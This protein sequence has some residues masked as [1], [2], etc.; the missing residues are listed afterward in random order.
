VAERGEGGRTESAH[1]A[2]PRLVDTTKSPDIL[3]WT[4]RRH[5][6]E[7]ERLLPRAGRPSSYNM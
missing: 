1:A 7:R 5:C 6:D 2:D 3:F 4:V